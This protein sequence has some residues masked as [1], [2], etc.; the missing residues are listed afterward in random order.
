MAAVTVAWD[1]AAFG[2]LNA[3]DATTGWSATGSGASPT[4][5]TDYYYQGTA[6]ISIQ[7]KTSVYTLTYTS[8][9]TDMNTTPRAWM[10][11]IIQTNKNA[12]DGNGL[13]LRIGSSNTVYYEYDLYNSNTYPTLGGF[14]IV[15]IAPSITNW[16]NNTV[17]T[18][19]N[20]A[21]TTFVGVTDAAFTAKAPNFGIDAI[22]VVNIGSGLTLT[23]GDAANTNGT[24][25]DF[26]DEDEG[27]ANNRWGHVQTRD[28]IIYVNGVLTI[29][30]S[31]T[32][33]EFTDS[34]KVLVFPD[35]RTSNGFNGVDFGINNTSTIDISSCVFNGRGSLAF[36]GVDTR[37]DY[38]ATGTAGTLTIADSTFNTFREM[39]LT[40][41]CIIDGC[42][43]LSAQTIVQ[44]SANLYQC[45][46]TDQATA[47]NEAQVQ[48]DIVTRIVSCDF[49]AGSNG[50][51]A[52]E[53]T[54]TG[55]YTWT[56][57]HS[58]YHAS[59]GQSNSTVYNS[60]GGAVTLNLATGAD[61]PTVRN[62]AGSTTSIVSSATLT[63]T[64]LIVE[65]EIQIVDTTNN[66]IVAGNNSINGTATDVTVSTGG[67]GYDNADVLTVSGGTGTS[68]TLNIVTDGS[69][70]IQTATIASGGNYTVEPTYPASH[71]GGSGSGG[72]FTLEVRGSWAYAYGGTPIYDIV[73]FHIN[74]KDIR[75]VDFDFPADDSSLFITQQTDRVYLNP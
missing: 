36:T 20:Q 4:V 57:T 16:A 56:I 52:V 73:I 46:F 31:T 8:T 70:V 30:N 2:R 74:Y 54:A 40:S 41:N 39:S 34:N 66:V 15:P 28:G 10:A 72:T 35:S 18:P 22:D 53:I 23:R 69:G 51:H 44:N 55:T 27:N 38:T 71:T 26:V 25:Q 32:N 11:K 68:A 13:I 19:N 12:I 9:S 60:S 7:V 5:E 21:V 45:V 62:G 75:F 17:G 67:T 48:S 1:A 37:P 47:V 6:C 63:I 65:T 49:T 61:T 43:I 29:G 24:F 58:G 59:N 64:N 33:T 14:V 3:A 42:A 50:G